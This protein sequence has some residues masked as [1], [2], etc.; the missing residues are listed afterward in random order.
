MLRFTMV[1]TTLAE[2]FP[3]CKH[4][5]GREEDSFGSPSL[6]LGL[7]YVQFMWRCDSDETMCSR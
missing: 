5:L 7:W 4:L 6:V 2:G 3:N 1:G